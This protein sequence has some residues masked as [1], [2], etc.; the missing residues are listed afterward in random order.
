[1]KDLIPKSL[2]SFSAPNDL[3][4]LIFVE[5]FSSLVSILSSSLSDERGVGP[6]RI[7]SKDVL[8]SALCQ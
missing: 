2:S 5:A 3:M 1:M 7:N 8:A 4:I 6:G